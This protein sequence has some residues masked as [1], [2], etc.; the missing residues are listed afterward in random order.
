MKTN[1]EPTGSILNATRTTVDIIQYYKQLT[2][3]S[4]FNGSANTKY[5][6]VVNTH[7]GVRNVV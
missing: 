2:D 3:L 5:L 1:F 7:H 4:S 6:A